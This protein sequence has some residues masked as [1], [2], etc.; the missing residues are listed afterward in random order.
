[1]TS[2]SNL[3]VSFTGHAGTPP[4]YQVIR[5]LSVTI[6]PI[7]L[8]AF[9]GLYSIDPDLYLRLLREDRLIEWLTVVLLSASGLLS[10]LLVIQIRARSKHVH[11]FFLTFSVICIVGAL[12]EINWGQSYSGGWT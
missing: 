6:F 8:I 7:L 12:E 2:D 3:P 5:A 10:L 11:W 4:F 1:M 9:I